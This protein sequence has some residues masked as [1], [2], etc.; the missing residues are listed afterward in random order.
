MGIAGIPIPQL[1]QI[2]SGLKGGAAAAGKNP[3]IFLLGFPYI[4]ESAAPEESRAPLTGTVEQIGKDIESI[5]KLGVEHM[6]L[7][8]NAF[9]P[10]GNNPEKYVDSTVRL[11]DY[12]R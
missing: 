12:A 6:I 7:A 1:E 4:M 3:R 2:I 9:S 5:A 8:A 11:A 10:L